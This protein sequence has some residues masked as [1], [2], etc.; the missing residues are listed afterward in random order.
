MIEVLQKAQFGGVEGIVMINV[1][2]I[3]AIV[4]HGNVHY[5][6]IEGNSSPVVTQ[7]DVTKLITAFKRL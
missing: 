4:Q 1:S 5:I 2:K 6:Y 3:T 7:G